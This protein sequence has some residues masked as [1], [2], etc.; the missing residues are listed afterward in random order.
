MEASDPEASFGSVDP[1]LVLRAAHLI[2]AFAY[3]RASFGLPVDPSYGRQ[4]EVIDLDGGFIH[5]ED[6]WRRYHINMHASG[7]LF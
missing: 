6:D 3:G 7:C 2:P 1:A 5:E 4:L